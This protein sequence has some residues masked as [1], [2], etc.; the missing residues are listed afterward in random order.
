MDE[1]QAGLTIT[2][3]Y[4]MLDDMQDMTRTVL[5]KV[6]GLFDNEE[7]AG[8]IF[9]IGLVTTDHLFNLAYRIEGML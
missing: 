6:S 1:S 7:I 8:M 2:K 3:G 4:G 5:F 9:G